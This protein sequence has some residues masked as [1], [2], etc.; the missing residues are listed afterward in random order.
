MRG[1]KPP[2]WCVQKNTRIMRFV[3]VATLSREAGQP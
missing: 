3:G 2:A 1:E